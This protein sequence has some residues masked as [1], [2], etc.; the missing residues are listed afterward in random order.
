DAVVGGVVDVPHDIPALTGRDAGAL[1]H[2]DVVQLPP[3]VPAGGVVGEADPDV[4]LARHLRQRDEL[5]ARAPGVRGP[6][7]DRL[8]GLPAVDA[9]LDGRRAGG[10]VAVVHLEADGGGVVA[11]HVQ[12]RRHQGGG[13]LG[14]GAVGVGV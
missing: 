10:Q 9:D 6:L 1:A 14:A 11:G 5:L 3:P 13:R 4:A 2:E 8:P 7:L 12:R